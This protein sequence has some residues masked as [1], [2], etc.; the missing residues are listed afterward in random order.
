MEKLQNANRTEN[1]MNYDG[2]GIQQKE[3]NK[4]KCKTSKGKKVQGAIKLWKELFSTRL[5]HAKTLGF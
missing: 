3:G 2:E 5:A 4:I 1:L